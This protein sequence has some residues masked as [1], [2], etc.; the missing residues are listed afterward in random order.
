MVMQRPMAV[1]K[2]CCTNV[3]MPLAPVTAG[4]MIRRLPRR[5]LHLCKYQERTLGSITAKVVVTM[6]PQVVERRR[7]WRRV[8]NSH[9]KITLRV[10]QAASP[11]YISSAI[12]DTS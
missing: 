10:D 3:N 7:R 9:P 6:A 2:A 8:Y 1:S 5:R 4:A 11:C 12:L